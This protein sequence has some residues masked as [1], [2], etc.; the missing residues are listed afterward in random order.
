MK[1][2]ELSVTLLP[3]L[4]AY[5]PVIPLRDTVVFPLTLQPLSVN[6]PVSVD[7]VHRSLSSDRLVYCYDE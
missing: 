6:R 5:L 1:M 7:S 2:P 4:P 3:P